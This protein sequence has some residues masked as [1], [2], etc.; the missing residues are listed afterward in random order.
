MSSSDHTQGTIIHNFNAINLVGV[1]N[2][3]REGVQSQ[4]LHEPEQMISSIDPMT[5]RHID[6]LADG[7][8]TMYF[9]TEATRQAYTDEPIDHPFH[10]VD[11]L[12]DEGIDEG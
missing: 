11:N 4:R 6:D 7:K 8:I 5:G 12:Y 10:L 2:L 1:E 9:E 3:A